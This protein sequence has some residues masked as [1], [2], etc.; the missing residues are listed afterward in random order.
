MGAAVA[1]VVVA[2][3]AAAEGLVALLL[4]GPV[5]AAFLAS[6]KPEVSEPQTPDT[7]PLNRRLQTTDFLDP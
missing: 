6:P 3:V 2:V 1:V 4:G 5:H 7:Q